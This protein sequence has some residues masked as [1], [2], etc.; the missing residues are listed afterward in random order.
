MGK[1]VVKGGA[2]KDAA[3]E[4]LLDL[5]VEDAKVETVEDAGDVVTAEATKEFDTER[6]A[7]AGVFEQI[8]GQEREEQRGDSQ[9]P[10]GKMMSNPDAYE[11]AE[12]EEIDYPDPLPYRLTRDYWDG[13]EVRRSGTVMEFPEGYQP[14]SA[15]LVEKA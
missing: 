15:I 10:R 6:N 3:V 11:R 13:N 4:K 2:E 12:S 14:T 1:T 5:E 8:A 7:A 9:P